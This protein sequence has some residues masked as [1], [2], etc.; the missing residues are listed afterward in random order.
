MTLP[1]ISATRFCQSAATISLLL[2]IAVCL[3]WELWLAPLRPGGSW[4]AL[5]AL[6]LLTPLFGILHGRRYTY[7]W[8]S[9]LIQLYLLE[10]LTR[11]YSDNAMTQVLAAVE[12]V[13]ALAFFAATLCYARASAP[14]KAKRIKAAD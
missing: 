7:Q 3:L 6:P 12:V 1:A 9:L 8:A 10:G 5:K 13:L 14:P 4:L 11:A 2:L